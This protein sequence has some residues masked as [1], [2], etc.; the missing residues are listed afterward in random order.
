MRER[1]AR[2]DRQSGSSAMATPTG[3]RSWSVSSSRIRLS[4]SRWRAAT[5]SSDAFLS[6][7]S[8]PTPMTRVGRPASSK[9]TL[10]RADIQWTLSPGRTWRNSISSSARRP[11]DSRMADSTAVR[12]SG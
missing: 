4:R 11:M 8:M 9:K 6:V 7:I 1:L 5:R 12:S 3:R 2:I 10:P